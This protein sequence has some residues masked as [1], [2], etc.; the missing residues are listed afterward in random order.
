MVDNIKKSLKE[1]P[2]LTKSYYKNVQQKSDYDKL[3]EKS[4]DYTKKT[5]E[6]KNDYMNRMHDKLRDLSTLLRLTWLF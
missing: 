5:N 1:R 2:K 3:L 6:A 4:A